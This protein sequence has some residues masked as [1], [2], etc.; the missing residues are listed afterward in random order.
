[1]CVCVSILFM[2]CCSFINISLALCV[3][4]A[5]TAFPRRLKQLV[6][7]ALG[8]AE[9]AKSKFKSITQEESKRER[10]RNRDVGAG[11]KAYGWSSGKY[12]DADHV[13]LVCARSTVREHKL[14]K[15]SSSSSRREREKKTRMKIRIMIIDDSFV[16]CCCCWRKGFG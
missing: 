14:R 9:S 16:F 11:Q 15:I 12:D 8:E 5:R 7:C 10:E 6:G 13:C 4:L 3:F 2:L 1:M